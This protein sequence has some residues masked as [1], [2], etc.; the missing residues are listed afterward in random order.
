REKN[1]ESNRER[2]REREQAPE[3]WPCLV[4][5]LS[6]R[7]LQQA[8][9]PSHSAQQQDYR[10]AITTLSPQPAAATTTTTTT[11]Q[12]VTPQALP[13]QTGH[14]RGGWGHRILSERA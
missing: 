11:R 5:V 3:R 6:L 4:I 8:G 12:G 10:D 13:T 7:R 9:A 1:R 14:S 2:E